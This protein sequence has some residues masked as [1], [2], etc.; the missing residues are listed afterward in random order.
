MKRYSDFVVGDVRES[1][2]SVES[3]VGVVISHA[4]LELDGLEE[5]ALLFLSQ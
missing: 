3:F 4:D 5:L 2:G 1:D